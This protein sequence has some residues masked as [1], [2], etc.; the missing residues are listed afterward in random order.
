MY[1][2]MK[3]SVSDDTIPFNAT[4]PSQGF[5]LVETQEEEVKKLEIHALQLQREHLQKQQEA[6]WK[7]EQ[8]MQAV[9]DKK[10]AKLA[11]KIK[12][13]QALRELLMEHTNNP[14]KILCIDRMDE[15]ER[16]RKWYHDESKLTP[17]DMPY[18]DNANPPLH[19]ASKNIKQAAYSTVNRINDNAHIS[20]WKEHEEH[21][22]S[23]V[24]WNY[25][26]PNDNLCVRIFS[27]CCF[28]PKP[29]AIISLYSYSVKQTGQSISEKTANKII[30]FNEEITKV[31]D[32]CIKFLESDLN[33]T[34][35]EQY[36]KK[37][38]EYVSLFAQ[39]SQKCTAFSENNL[40]LYRALFFKVCKTTFDKPP[41][42]SHIEFIPPP[43]TNPGYQ[44]IYPTSP[45][46]APQYGSTGDLCQQRLSFI[47]LQNGAN[48]Q[49]QGSNG[50]SPSNA[51]L[52]DTGSSATNCTTPKN[53][54][55]TSP[56]SPQDNETL[57]QGHST[58]YSDASH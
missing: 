42:L 11:E 21:G 3:S 52:N 7:H 46:T 40:A 23:K 24:S 25:V 39:S 32:F 17:E 58:E 55:C 41:K 10:N 43:E 56:H 1:R 54:V 16:E 6:A 37:I 47:D 38:K 27:G 51:S 13:E 29:K 57:L 15:E 36:E 9:L 48:M 44:H 5:E 18:L 22:I 8:E 19:S 33:N 35:T 20:D 4:N 50:N 14:N 2:V 49:S 12:N 53:A 26:V 34:D 45:P 30:Q 28:V 31:F